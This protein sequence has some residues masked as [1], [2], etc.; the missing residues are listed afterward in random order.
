MY[1]VMVTA[2]MLVLPAL[3]IGAEVLA[4]GTAFTAAL[5]L[6]WFAFWSVGLRLFLAGVRQIARPEFT[7]MMILGQKS[8]DAVDFIDRTFRADAGFTTAKPA[9]ALELGSRGRPEIDDDV[10]ADM[11]GQDARFLVV[12]AVGH[13]RGFDT[14]PIV[15]RRG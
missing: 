10:F 8:A 14:R 2:L 11:G 7:A 3:S 5:V 13:H 12:Q 1:I 4:G 6:K 15:R 9:G